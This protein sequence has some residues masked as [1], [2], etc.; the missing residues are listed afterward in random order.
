M[1]PA[2][3]TTLPREPEDGT[4][5]LTLVSV[6]CSSWFPAIS[7]HPFLNKGFYFVLCMLQVCFVFLFLSSVFVTT[8]YFSLFGFLKSLAYKALCLS[9]AG[10]ASCFSFQEGSQEEKEEGWQVFRGKR[11]GGRRQRL[12]V[13]HFYPEHLP[14]PLKTVCRIEWHYIGGGHLT[15]G[16]GGNSLNWFG[17]GCAL[18]KISCWTCLRRKYLSEAAETIWENGLEMKILLWH[19]GLGT[20]ENNNRILAVK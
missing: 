11:R 4:G 1:P 5:L 2:H 8:S 10:F 18:G 17:S 3:S 7:P 6:L 13:S 20:A 14:S 12:T 15:Q 16:C 19:S 9:C